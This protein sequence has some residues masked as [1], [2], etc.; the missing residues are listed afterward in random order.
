ML[1]AVADTRDLA[2]LVRAAQADAWQALGGLFDGCGG[3][4][5]SLRGMRVMASGLPHPQWNGADVG[6]VD[7]DIEA[8]RAFF[9][10]RGV[11][12]GARVPAAMAWRHGRL[13]CRQRLMGLVA[14]GDFDPAP[15]PPGFAVQTAGTADLESVLAVDAE[16]FES[17]AAAGRPWL[18]ALLAAPAEVVTVAAGTTAGGRTVGTGY[19]VL[20]DGVAGPS[21]CIAGI[22]VARDCRRRGLGA[23]LSSWLVRRG[24]DAG[25]RLAHLQPDDDRAARLYARLGFIETDGLDIYVDL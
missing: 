25:A 14:A 4:T 3:G 24:F 20:S 8:A 19:A 11:P 17:D 13:L 16:A 7:A 9:A 10:E 12:W 21:V 2:D 23:A 5:A 22:A 6:A 1:G 15:V 18:A